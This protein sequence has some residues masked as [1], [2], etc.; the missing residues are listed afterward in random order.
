M[1]GRFDVVPDEILRLIT[2]LIDHGAAHRFN[3]L[4]NLRRGEFVDRIDRNYPPAAVMELGIEARRA[5]GDIKDFLAEI[6]R[7]QRKHSHVLV[8]RS[9]PRNNVIQLYGHNAISLSTRTMETQMNR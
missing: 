8:E 6:I 2:H 5:G 7:R 4:A 3:A 9:A 1:L